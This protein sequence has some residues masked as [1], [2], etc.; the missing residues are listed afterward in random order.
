MKQQEAQDEE[1]GKQRGAQIGLL[2]KQELSPITY[3]SDDGKK[4][5]K[6]MSRLGGM[7]ESS[8]SSQKRS[9]DME[10]EKEI[11]ETK[12]KKK[13]LERMMIEAKK[14]EEE[15][16]EVINCE[17]EKHFRIWRI[18]RI[19]NNLAQTEID[20]PKGLTKQEVGF[21]EDKEDRVFAAERWKLTPTGMKHSYYWSGSRNQKLDD[22][23]KEFEDRAAQI[24]DD[25]QDKLMC[26]EHGTLIEVIKVQ[27]KTLDEYPAP[28]RSI[29]AR[30][31]ECLDHF[32]Y[33]TM[34]TEG[35]NK[36][37]V[38][39]SLLSPQGIVDIVWTGH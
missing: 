28:R 1:E 6:L 9:W 37:V 21:D 19:A 17:K 15:L 23:Q 31:R 33:V 16:R 25:V 26:A 2:L 29:L 38:Q 8:D 27:A 24:Y 5:K 20:Q 12:L 30:T 18:I 22:N 14:G 3:Y 32:N 34:D 11:L 36:E 13:M 39:M 4:R 10:T 7:R 35:Q